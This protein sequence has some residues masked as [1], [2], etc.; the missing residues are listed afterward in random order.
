MYESSISVVI[1]APQDAVWRALT[2]PDLITRYFFGTRLETDWKPGSD[3]T[4]SGEWEGQTYQDRGTVLT[5]SPP[6]ALSYSYWSG[7]S[8]TEDHPDRRMI[9]HYDLQPAG[10]AVQLTVRTSGCDTKERAEHSSQ[11]WQHVLTALR[12]M[13]ETS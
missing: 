5:F 2:E 7:F 8:G 6:S 11:N 13:L 1:H 9:I 4:F 3:M 10:D 12:Q